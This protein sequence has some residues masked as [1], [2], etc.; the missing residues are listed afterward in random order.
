MSDPSFENWLTEST[1]ALKA[2][3]AFVVAKIK[4]FVR[5]DIGE[6][7][8][9]SFF[10]IEPSYRVKDMA[11]A[12]KKQAKKNY[13]DPR[14]AM[15]DLVG[16][17]FVVLVR[18]DI[19]IV[20]R[21]LLA[22]S[23]WSTSRD[24]HFRDEVI[25][26]PELFDYQSVHYLVRATEETEIDG[27]RIP[28]GLPCEVQIRTLLQHAYAELVHDNIYKPTVRVPSSAKRLVARSMALM[29]TTDVMFCQALHELDQVTATVAE[30]ERFANELYSRI[31]GRAAEDVGSPDAMEFIETYRDLFV[32][33]N[34]AEFET[35]LQGGYAQRL[36]ERSAHPGLFAKPISVL[37]YWLAREH[38]AE[39]AERWHLPAYRRD[40]QLILADLGKATDSFH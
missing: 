23:G 7:R 8:Y 28:D 1:P 25:D 36:R 32:S 9:K 35:F 12:L 39:L 21:A 2:W 34:R 27:I 40:L 30:L 11:S 22:Y 24:R 5:L 4:A 37:V 6:D 16:A 33:C 31:C 18:T 38:D 20:E 17:R 19:E 10:K 29:E 13:P 14:V 26:N 3:G 15:T